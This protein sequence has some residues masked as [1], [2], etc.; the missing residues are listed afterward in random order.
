MW[1]GT[2]QASGSLTR[3]SGLLLETSFISP[4]GLR[5]NTNRTFITWRQTRRLSPETSSTKISSGNN[6][7]FLFL[8]LFL[9]FKDP[10]LIRV[11]SFSKFVNIN[12]S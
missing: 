1:S 4:P 5:I 11:A 2:Q 7:S 9:D 3:D 12:I 8:F 10:T 6:H